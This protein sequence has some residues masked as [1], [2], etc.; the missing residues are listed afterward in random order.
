MSKFKKP[1]MRAGDVAKGV[2]PMERPYLQIHTAAG[3]RQ[4]VLGKEP[5]SIG[6]HKENQLV[7]TDDMASRFHCV[8]ERV[9]DGFL[10]RDLGARNGTRVNGK[11]VK[12]A[13]LQPGDEMT[14]G[15]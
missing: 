8:I 12:S 2:H 7:L 10:L 9:P 5:L 4:L 11:V 3:R 1:A 6:R 14:I 15:S 13:L